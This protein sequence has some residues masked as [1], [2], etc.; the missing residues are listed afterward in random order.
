VTFT[1]QTLGTWKLGV[2][3]KSGAS[4]YTLNVSYPDARTGGLRAVDR[5]RPGD[6]R[7]VRGAG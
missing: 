6:R 3:A 5:A 7:P 1:A 4:S 2:K